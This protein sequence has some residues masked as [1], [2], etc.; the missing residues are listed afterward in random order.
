MCLHSGNIHGG[1]QRVQLRPV[2]FELVVIDGVRVIILP[3]DID[4]PEKFNCMA[5]ETSDITY[6]LVQTGA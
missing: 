4:T 5:Y 1:I 2:L 3:L 6:V